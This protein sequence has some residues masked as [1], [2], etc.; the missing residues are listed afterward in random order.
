MNAVRHIVD[1]LIE[2]DIRRLVAAGLPRGS[3]AGQIKRWMQE[4][5][6]EVME[7]KYFR[8]S[9]GSDTI[10]VHFRQPEEGDPSS[11]VIRTKIWYQIKLGLHKLGLNIEQ[12]TVPSTL[13]DGSMLVLIT[14]LN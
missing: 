1:M 11:T 5:G 12:I 13:Y 10:R 7:I 14:V 6:W 8:L 3:V 9:M 2:T 4:K